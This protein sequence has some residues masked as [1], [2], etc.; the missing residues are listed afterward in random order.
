[1]KKIS[2]VTEVFN[3]HNYFLG[4]TVLDI[5]CGTGEL[6][7]WMAEQGAL[8]TGLDKDSIIEIAQMKAYNHRA[9]F[10]SGRAE[11]L[12]FSDLSVDIITYIASYHHIPITDM[13]AAMSEAYRVLK[14]N[15]L[16]FFLEPVP[17]KDTYYEVTRLVED[18]KTVL[19]KV[20]NIIKNSV[21][22]HFKELREEYYFLERSFEDYQALIAF[23][24]SDPVKAEDALNKAITVFQYYAYRHNLPLDQ[25]RF[26]SVMRLNILQKI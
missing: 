4:K 17:E 6:T 13:V 1:M 26:K 11:K 14:L 22:D 15:G 5:G 20:R 2:N 16:I 25:F 10:I 24:V 3:S 19:L 21:A 7:S 9:H 8:V 23:H 12:S 18:E